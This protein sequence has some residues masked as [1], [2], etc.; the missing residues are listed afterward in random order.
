MSTTEWRIKRAG[1]RCSLFAWEDRSIRAPE[2]IEYVAGIF[3]SD[4]ERL[5]V[6][7]MRLE[8]LGIDAAVR[9]GR[10]EDWKAAIADR[11]RRERA[12]D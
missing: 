5:T 9:F 3:S 1:R 2:K 6:L 8:N 12:D 11:E 7:G 4:H 10:L